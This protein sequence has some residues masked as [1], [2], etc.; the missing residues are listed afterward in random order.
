MP[1]RNY[2]LLTRRFLFPLALLLA[3]TNAVGQDRAAKEYT[4]GYPHGRYWTVLN[5]FEKIVYV[6]GFRDGLTLGAAGEVGS[7]KVLQA[8]TEATN[9][10]FARRFSF[11]EHITEIDKIYADQE[12]LLIPIPMAIN[13]CAGKLRGTLTKAELEQ[14]LMDFRRNS[15]APH[16]KKP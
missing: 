15:P 6:Q 8:M 14:I 13:Y 3:G 11:R 7:P 4:D 16:E 12:N 2:S 10:Y 1:L 9:S 5:V